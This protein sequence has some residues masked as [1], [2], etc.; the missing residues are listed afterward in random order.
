MAQNSEIVQLMKKLCFPPGFVVDLSDW[1]N[2]TIERSF[3]HPKEFKQVDCISSL[4]DNIILK[5]TP[6]VLVQ[7]LA[8][9]PGESCEFIVKFIDEHVPHFRIDNNVHVGM[10]ANSTK[11]FLTETDDA[12]YFVGTNDNTEREFTRMQIGYQ[13]RASFLH[14]YKAGRIKCIEHVAY[15]EDV[16]KKYVVLDLIA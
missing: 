13:N 16:E 14:A 5:C 3:P 2:L 6:D 7:I 10:N 15:V 11:H 4:I 8:K 12:I 1:Y 9:C